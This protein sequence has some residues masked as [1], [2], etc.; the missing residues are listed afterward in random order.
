MNVCKVWDAEYPWDVRAEKVSLS[1]TE[2]GHDVHLVARN[3]DVRSL[4]ES[5]TEGTVHRMAPLPLGGRRLN[6]ASMFPAFF[7]P[8][9]IRLIRSVARETSADVIVCRDIPLAP[10]CVMIGRR[11][12]IPV[13]LDMAENYPAMMKAIWDHGRHRLTDWLVR[14]P[15]VV[16]WVERWV[17]HKVDHIV[18]VVEESGDRLVS[19]GV[20]ESRITVVPNTPL[21]RRIPAELNGA[22]PTPPLELVYIG[23]LE[24][25]RGIQVVLNALALCRQANLPVHFSV[26]GDGRDQS[27]LEEQA[28][29]LGLTERDVRFHGRL[30]YDEALEVVKGAHVGIVP[31]LANPSWNSTI[32][33]KLFDYMSLGLP[34][35]TSDA[36]PAARIVETTGCG[37]VYQS[38]DPEGLFQAIR[39]LSDESRR[40][41]LGQEGRDAVLQRFRWRHDG[42]RF[43]EAVEKVVAG[44]K[45][46]T[47]K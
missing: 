7:N 37:R 17:I 19:L 15:A 42:A 31:H 32:P 21:D 36:K 22:P 2:A 13:V 39:A 25:P 40:E 44:H 3:R 1:L 46:V 34:V 47:A 29:S 11:L 43:V 14:N 9:W 5:L 16:R 33:N 27:L 30:P 35:I 10:T 20:P 41:R 18:V 45:T 4:R 8:R 6:A 24:A 38:E 26:V 12:S 23:L 28:R